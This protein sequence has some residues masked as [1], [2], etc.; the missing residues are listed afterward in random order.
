MADIG[1]QGQTVNSKW[2]NQTT[3][4]SVFLM[5]VLRRNFSQLLFINLYHLQVRT[6]SWTPKSRECGPKWQSLKV[7]HERFPPDGPE[8]KNMCA[9][10]NTW[11]TSDKDMVA[12]AHKYTQTGFIWAGIYCGL[13]NQPKHWHARLEM[14]AWADTAQLIQ[15]IVAKQKTSALR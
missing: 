11:R 1:T 7:R 14:R 8:K 3:T 6:W 2:T 15:N 9:Y 13:A 4:S 12:C 10:F 5:F